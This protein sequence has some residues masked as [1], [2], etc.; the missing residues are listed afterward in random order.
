MNCLLVGLLQVVEKRCAF[1]GRAR[2]G[3]L[4]HRGAGD[5][6][7]R[8][9]DELRDQLGRPSLASRSK[10]FDAGGVWEALFGGDR[11]SDHAVQIGAR[12]DLGLIR[13]DA[14]AGEAELERA[15][16]GVVD[17]LC[18]CRCARRDGGERTDCDCE[19]PYDAD[20]P[21]LM[22]VIA[23]SPSGR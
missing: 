5:H 7:L 11:A 14:M 6:R 20:A 16:A 22:T 13:L 15:F 10:G 1:F 12:Q 19:A 9:L 17:R 4:R 3:R 2:A 8:I 21:V 18:E 23:P